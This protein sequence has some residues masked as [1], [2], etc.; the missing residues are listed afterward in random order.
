LD[1]SL[2][3]EVLDLDELARYVVEEARPLRE[4]HGRQPSSCSR[5]RSEPHR[6]RAFE[7]R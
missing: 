5:S 3:R 7:R 4:E 6:S 1:I 2:Q